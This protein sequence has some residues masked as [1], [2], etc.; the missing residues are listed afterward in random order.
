MGVKCMTPTSVP[1]P[2]TC[3]SQQKPGYRKNGLEKSGGDYQA[4][5]LCGY[6]GEYLDDYPQEYRYSDDQ[7][8]GY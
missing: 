5:Y 6:H 1:F 4:K 3:H 7:G 2:Q 8:I